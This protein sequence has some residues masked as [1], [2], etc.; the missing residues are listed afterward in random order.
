MSKKMKNSSS[1]V[2]GGKRPSR[3]KVEALESRQ[4]LAS[5]VVGGREV[6]SNADGDGVGPSTTLVD[7]VLMTAPSITVN[8]DPG[9]LTRVSWL[10]ADGDIVFAEFGGG[11]AAQTSLTITLDQSAGNAPLGTGPVVSPKY[12]AQTFAA[13][14][15][16]TDPAGNSLAG[17]AGTPLRYLQGNA[18][19]TV[20][21]AD[22]STYLSVYSLGNDPYR[23]DPALVA[24]AFK[25]PPTSGPLGANDGVAN[26]KAIIIAANANAAGVG[27]APGTVGNINFGGIGAA[28]AVFSGN[29]G[30]VG[31]DAP[32][33]NVV[34]YVQIGDIRATDGGV[35][36]L[37][38][39]SIQTGVVN[40]Y[41]GRFANT[42]FQN[43]NFA[44]GT[45]GVRGF[46]SAVGQNGESS[47]GPLVN[48]SRVATDGSRVPGATI[49]SG[50]IFPAF[51]N[52]NVFAI[53]PV[54][55]DQTFT[56]DANTTQASLDTF[57][58]GRTFLGNVIVTGDLR[59]D[60]AIT[61]SA[62]RGNLTIN[63]SLAGQ[64][65]V[66]RGG[67]NGT[68]TVRDDLSSVINIGSGPGAFVNGA[69][70][71]IQKT[72]GALVVGRDITAS[73]SI[74]ANQIG[75]VTVGR[76]LAG[77]L[78]TDAVV[79]NG[80]FDPV[81]PAGNVGTPTVFEGSIGNVS[82]GRDLTG[83]LVGI[84]GV[85]NVNVTRN[86][87]GA[88]ATTNGV[89]SVIYTSANDLVNNPN[90]AQ[91]PN[92]TLGTFSRANVGTLTVG[93]DVDITAANLV[94]INT[95]GTYGNIT[96]NGTGS[97]TTNNALRAQIG[98]IRV[99]TSL[100]VQGQVLTTGTITVA[101]PTAGTTVTFGGVTVAANSDVTA[102]HSVAGTLGAITFTGGGAGTILNLNG[103]IGN[104]GQ[105]GAGVAGADKI[106]VSGLTASAFQQINALVGNNFAINGSSIGPISLSL[107]DVPSTTGANALA[108]SL[109]FSGAVTA[110]DSV[111]TTGETI[112]ALTL[113]AGVTNGTLI[114]TGT[115]ATTDNGTVGGSSIGAVALTGRTLNMGVN[116]A[117]GVVAGGG[118]VS[119]GTIGA[120][121]ITS[122]IAPQ[123]AVSAANPN[124]PATGAVIGGTGGFRASTLLTSLTV[125]ARSTVTSTGLVDGGDF[126]APLVN[127]NQP[128]TGSVGA[129]TFSGTATPTTP[130]GQAPT[131]AISG[132]D[133]I[134]VVNI[135][136]LNFVGTTAF[137]GGENIIVRGTAQTITL[138]GNT[139]F[140]NAA[141]AAASIRLGSSTGAITIGAA[142][143]TSTATFVGA[144]ILANDGTSAADGI[145]SV[146]INGRV[147]GHFTG[148][149]STA[150]IQASNIGGVTIIGD[151]GLAPSQSLVTSLGIR[152]VNNAAVGGVASTGEAVT[153]AN[154][155]SYSI[156]N[157]IVT[158]NLSQPL[159]GNSI[160][161]GL[162]SIV[163]QGSIG[164]VNITG[165]LSGVQQPV[166]FSTAASGLT[167][168][169]G[170]NGFGL[171]RGVDFNGNGAI[172]AGNE[173]TSAFAAAATVAV[174][175]TGGVT[176]NAGFATGT[177]TNTGVTNISGGATAG[178]GLSVLSGVFTNGVQPIN[179]NAVVA[180]RQSTTLTGN[181]GAV[182][183]R[184]GGSVLFSS[185]VRQGTDG[186]VA[187]NSTLGANIV[188]PA[189]R[190]G[191]V[192]A[193]SIAGVQSVPGALN[194]V[195]AGGG[196]TSKV[197]ILGDD[198][199]VDE[200]PSTV[201][202]FD[203]LLVVVV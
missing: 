102:P 23:V 124:P 135:G 72:I 71:A 28:N 92:V 163:A 179:A 175:A 94:N 125:N 109:T 41:G 6:Q 128:V 183:V 14:L 137:S 70:N 15:P 101:E 47:F 139:T 153:A 98:A 46:A 34:S 203:Q 176:V 198:N 105:V 189:V 21:N 50:D 150:D 49:V 33:V 76:D 79:A 149:A 195:D 129:V 4:L 110:N 191:I 12:N 86:I 170:V 187:A 115:V 147:V 140:N 91:F 48:G 200:N 93:G 26:I 43:N 39:N 52:T 152:A 57:F 193:D 108:T 2:V 16:A 44:G 133:A 37:N 64:L 61:A 142:D 5:M 156:G 190:S 117:G 161:T 63:G 73:A 130:A 169:A 29:N 171:T 82:V 20:S 97:L 182:L 75:N 58:N 11:S 186:G 32:Q 59:P 8:T 7:Q 154:L 54:S 120:A 143:G 111:G 192:A 126:I 199:G 112:G 145:A 19:L 136:A 114:F 88:G 119:S 104:A 144:G 158:A 18:T 67:I 159:A 30:T 173:A 103:T 1:P 40:V 35:P 95:I 42:F 56:I 17:L 185:V 127:G 202:N 167:I 107:S 118:T 166:L 148:A 45:G 89:A 132:A 77:V 106:A 131:T 188:N 24:T 85:G 36:S 100:G 184:N 164:S 53:T 84:G 138:S 65:N 31:I 99:G 83:A 13:N 197:V 9:Q 55:G 194:A 62:F 122:D 174:G 181:I 25:N 10:D 121:T 66:T 74:L 201:E 27:V 196:R 87:T 78:S 177:A 80:T 157:V 96:V 113:N 38:F 172:E 68:L 162:N 160:F 141:N 151:L 116:A 146:T 180:Q 3:F 51:A 178:S 134:D 90:N 155:G 165:Q 22:T 168:A 60:L 81:N 123:V 69:N